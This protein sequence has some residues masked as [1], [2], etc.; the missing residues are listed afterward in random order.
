[1]S[2]IWLKGLRERAMPLTAYHGKNG[3]SESKGKKVCSE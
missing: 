2:E 3:K 1:M